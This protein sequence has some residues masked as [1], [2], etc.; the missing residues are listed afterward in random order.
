MREKLSTE[1]GLSMRVIQGEKDIIKFLQFRLS[2]W[3]QNRRSKERRMKQIKQC[4]LSKRMYSTEAD[5]HYQGK[6]IDLQKH[7]QN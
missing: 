2:V 1:T 4:D 7:F 6:K 5:F 3:F